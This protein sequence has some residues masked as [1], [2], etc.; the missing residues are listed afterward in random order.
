MVP[1]V[2]IV[3]IQFGAFLSG[4]VIVETV[5]GVPGI[6]GLIVERIL[7]RDYPVVQGAVLMLAACMIAVNLV[8]DL[9]YAALDP[10]IRLT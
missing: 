9:L 4:L 2:T 10:R 8:I 7:A 5:F 6:G 3:G 1:V